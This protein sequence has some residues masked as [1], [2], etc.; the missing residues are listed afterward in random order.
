MQAV[1]H[2]RP[3]G[4]DAWSRI[5]SVGVLVFLLVEIEKAVIRGWQTR[6]GRA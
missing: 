3:I 4:I 5:L 2:T 1:F 6:S